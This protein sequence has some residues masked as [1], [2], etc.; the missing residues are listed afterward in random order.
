MRTID[1][2]CV[3]EV[4]GMKAVLKSYVQEAIDVEKAGLKVDFRKDDLVFPE[5][6]VDKLSEDPGLNAAFGALTPGRRRGYV[7]HFS[8]PKQSKTRLSRIGKCA[9]RILE[10]K[11]LHDR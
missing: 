2:A 4:D 7:L 11:G 3:A 9:P 5:E 1:F 10:G 6:L 8:A